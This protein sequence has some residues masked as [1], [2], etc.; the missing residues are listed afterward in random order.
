M[1]WIKTVSE[2][3]A[4]GKLREYYEAEKTPSGAVDNILK[5]HSLDP[6]SLSWH[7]AMYRQLMYG[8]GSRLSRTQRE[9]IAVVVSSLNHCRY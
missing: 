2:Q 8:R 1:A 4:E 3:D 7:V 9:M 6:D 5:I